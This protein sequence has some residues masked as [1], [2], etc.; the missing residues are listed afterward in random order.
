M[1]K[2]TIAQMMTFWVDPTMDSDPHSASLVHTHTHTT[3]YTVY[4]RME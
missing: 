1:S 2:S 4:N 3:H